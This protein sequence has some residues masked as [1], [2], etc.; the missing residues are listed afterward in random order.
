MTVLSGTEISGIYL[1]PAGVFREPET[2]PH[3][4]Q[5]QNNEDGV[6]SSATRAQSLHCLLSACARFKFLAQN[7]N[8][9]VSIVVITIDRIFVFC[10]LALHIFTT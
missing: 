6:Y 10:L 7:I 3:C 2:P 1:S 4:H 5:P 9:P 8:Q